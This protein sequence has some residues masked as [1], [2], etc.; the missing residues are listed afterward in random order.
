[1]GLGTGQTGFGAGREIEITSAAMRAYARLRSL[2]RGPLA[3][4]PLPDGGVICEDRAHFAR[5]TMWRI[6]SD[7]TVLADNRYSFVRRGFV[8]TA[9]PEANCRPS[10]IP[11]N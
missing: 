6:L 1:M 9:I 4:H 5:P 7:G 10:G 8:T 11:S 3:A 2:S